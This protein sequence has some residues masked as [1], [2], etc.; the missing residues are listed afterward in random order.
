MRRISIL[1]SHIRITMAYL[2]STKRLSSHGRRLFHAVTA[3]AD[4]T[5]AIIR[6]A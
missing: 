4:S 5:Q 1:P 6:Y 3:G 2:E